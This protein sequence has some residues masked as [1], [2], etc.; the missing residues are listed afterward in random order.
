[1]A[2]PIKRT[3]IGATAETASSGAA[4]GI[5]GSLTGFF[6][7]GLVGGLAGAAVVATVGAVAGLLGGGIAGVF[8]A[9]MGGYALAGAATLAQGGA[10]LGGIVGSLAGAYYGTLAGGMI[11]AVR[12]VINKAN[13]I[14]DDEKLAADVGKS[15]ELQNMQQM[16]AVREQAAEQYTQMGYQQGLQDGQAAVVAQLQQAAL[17]QQAQ[18]AEHKSNFVEREA[19]RRHKKPEELGTATH[20]E[21]AKASKEAANHAALGA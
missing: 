18:A 13:R 12:G 7:G 8:A 19:E 10:Y 20:A 2:Q 11:G 6:G 17:A 1:M 4:N 21:H 16:A 9:D 3:A 14:S 15:K 5:L